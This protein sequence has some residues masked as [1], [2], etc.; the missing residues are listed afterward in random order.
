MQRYVFGKTEFDHWTEQNAKA[1][2]PAFADSVLPIADA[3]K[4]DL[5]RN[6]HVIGDHIRILPTPGHTSGH[7]A[8]TLGRGKDDAVICGD[9]MHTPLQTRYPE[10]SANSTPI[11]SRRP[12]RDVASWNVIATPRRCVARRISRRPRPARF[13]GMATGFLAR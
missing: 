4:A 6:D 8:F 13:A 3:G 10:L 11:R 9:L 2:V 5:V 12:R 7:I 1:E